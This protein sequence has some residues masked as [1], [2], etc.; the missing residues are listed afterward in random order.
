MIVIFFSSIG[1]TPTTTLSRRAT[2]G[3]Q[4]RAHLPYCQ[5]DHRQMAKTCVMQNGSEQ[6]ISNGYNSNCN[7]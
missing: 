5:M 7:V 6:E 1:L 2:N 3:R 4:R